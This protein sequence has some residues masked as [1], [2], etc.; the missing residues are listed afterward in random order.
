M[1]KII[2]LK[3][4][5]LKGGASNRYNNISFYKSSFFEDDQVL[6]TLEK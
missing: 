3:G 6:K 1:V 5:P 4:I 2:K